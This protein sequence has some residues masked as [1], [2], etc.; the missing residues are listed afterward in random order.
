MRIKVTIAAAALAGAIVLG[1]GA[2]AYPT[3]F[4]TG[5]TINEPGVSEGYFIIPEGPIVYMLDA[6]G[7]QLHS[8]TPLSGWTYVTRPLDNGHLLVK[9]TVTEGVY[10]IVELDW[11]SNV[12]WA[13]TQ[14]P[15]GFP[16]ETEFHHDW[17]RLDNGNTMI[18]ARYQGLYPQVSDR[19]IMNDFIIEVNPAGEIVWEWY[20]ADHFDEFGFTQ[21]RIDMIYA[22]GGDWSHMNS[23]SVIPDN[24]FHSDPRFMPGNLIVSYRYQG[25]AVIDRA[26]GEIVWFKE[27]DTIGQHDATMIPGDYPGGGNILT[28]DNGWSAKWVR[29]YNRFHSRILEIDPVTKEIAWEYD[30]QSSNLPQWTFFSPSASGVQRLPG[31]NTLICETT[32]GRVFEITP[33]GELVW[34]FIHPFRNPNDFNANNLYRAYK[35]PLDWASSYFQPDLTVSIAEDVDP[36]PGGEVL[37][38]AIQVDNAGTDPAVNVQLSESTPT[39]TSFHS[40]LAPPEWSCTTPAVGSTGAISCTAPDMSAGATALF[41]LGV[42]VDPCAMDGM[43]ISSFVSVSSDGTEATPSNNSAGVGTTVSETFCDDSNLCTTDACFADACGFQPLLCDPPP[44]PCREPG[45]CDPGTGLCSYDVSSD[46]TGCDDADPTTCDDFCTGGVCAGT[47]VPAPGEI[48]DDSVRVS[49]AAGT[50]TISWTDT[51]GDW[52]NVY[53]GTITPGSLFS[54][55]HACLNP[56]GP[57]N[58][59]NT[60]DPGVPTA[61]DAAYYVVTR[62]EQCRDSACGRSSAGVPRPLPFPCSTT[63]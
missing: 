20:T 4:D 5:V 56:E 43:L 42:R 11:N 46:G 27:D 57:L 62:V 16:A 35:V 23:V 26:T 19:I 49:H 25:I 39:G 15:A 33:T 3:I 22:E 41:S 30:A 61:G 58:K 45:V 17:I 12:V 8:W 9:T 40:L 48:D 50:T 37:T 32:S 63:K 52:F 60:A 21:E 54:Y 24:T 31:G 38:Y 47:F 13:F 2:L 29:D 59:A 44:E 6:D 18:L 14:P 36:V 51:P 1:T 53:A 55:N 34:E 7:T 10:G 28:F